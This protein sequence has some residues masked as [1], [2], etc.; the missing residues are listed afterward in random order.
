[1]NESYS[2]PRTFPWEFPGAPMA[3]VPVS[4]RV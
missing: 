2:F 4:R 1:M 3:P